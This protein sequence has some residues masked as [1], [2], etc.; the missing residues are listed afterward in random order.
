MNHTDTDSAPAGPGPADPAFAPAPLPP[1]TP[2][3]SRPPAVATSPGITGGS[4][5]P[6]A[7]ARP[8][9]PAAAPTADLALPRRRRT[10]PERE[11]NSWLFPAIA[12]AL[13]FVLL[14]G[15]GLAAWFSATQEPSS[16]PRYQ[17]RPVVST[18][19]AFRA[20]MPQAPEVRPLVF[21]H[22]GQSFEGSEW[23]AKGDDYRYALVSVDTSRLGLRLHLI[24]EFA[25]FVAGRLGCKLG[26]ARDTL[27]L[28]WPA[29]EYGLGAPEA[30]RLLVVRSEARLYAASTLYSRDYDE[31]QARRFQATLEIPA[32]VGEVGPRADIESGRVVVAGKPFEWEIALRNCWNDESVRVEGLP[33]GVQWSLQ[34]RVLKIWGALD[35]LGL[36]E[37]TVVIA[38]RT[39][40]VVKT[41]SFECVR[42]D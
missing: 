10:S 30:G 34:G 1:G 33:A 37:F 39:G 31:L 7:A 6:V 24:Q 8:A 4:P 9:A 23:Q 5:P 32:N 41:V 18:P 11:R 16:G 17:W 38:W 42:L 40:Q 14:S 26:P 36:V 22:A 35:E 28:G 21:E 27:L 13:F 3:A 20:E 19:G 29:R 2:E 25:E 12:L 15:L